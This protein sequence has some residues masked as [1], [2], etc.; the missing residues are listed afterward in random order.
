M[1]QFLYEVFGLD[2]LKRSE[3]GGTKKNRKQKEIYYTTSSY[4]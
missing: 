3:S 2:Y 4:Q 1:G